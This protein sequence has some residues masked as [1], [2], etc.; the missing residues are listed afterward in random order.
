MTFGTTCLKF[1]KKHKIGEWTWCDKTSEPHYEFT[2]SELDKLISLKIVA[3]GT[4]GGLVIGNLHSEGG[5]HLIYPI[6]DN[7]LRYFG[8]MEGWEYLTSP[9]KKQ[10]IRESFIDINERTKNQ[11]RHIKTEFNIP[12]NC[13][14]IDVSGIE[15]PFLIILEEH[16]IIN[17]FATQNSINELIELDLINNT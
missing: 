7:R 4:K 6:S 12:D 14:I 1:C 13:N 15:V 17:R 3:N 16:F 10:H 8:E 9:L 2:L 11:G 5:I